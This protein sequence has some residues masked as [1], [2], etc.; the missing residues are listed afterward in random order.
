[1]PKLHEL[2]AVEGQLKGQSEATRKDLEATFKKKTH[3]FE[4]K[5]VTF[6]SSEENSTAVT[7]AQSDIQSTVPKELK[8]IAGIMG[9]QMDVSYNVADADTI[10]RADVILD[11][12]VVLLKNVPTTALLELEKRCAEIQSLI[13]VAPT[14]DPAKGFATDADQGA[15]IYKARP[16]N[17]T[18]T[19]KVPKVITLAPATDKH[20]AQA[21]LLS[22]DVPVGTVTEQEWSAMLTPAIKA[23]LLGRVEEVKRAVKTARSR[24]NDTVLVSLGNVAAPI[25][26]YILDG[27]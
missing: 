19:K 20:P 13:D 4:K 12:G 15:N 27:K 22:E 7:E 10:A 24:A 3:L 14:L 23:E 1:M 26:T 5:L 8:W 2:L 21:Q 6:V 11:S 16:V 9:K 25:F 17:K 18:R